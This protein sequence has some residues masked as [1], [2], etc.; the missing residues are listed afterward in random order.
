MVAPSKKFSREPTL[1]MYQPINPRPHSIGA[2]ALIRVLLLN[3]PLLATTLYP[4]WIEDGYA[5]S[6][7]PNLRINAGAYREVGVIAES[8]NQSDCR[9]TAIF[10]T[11][12]VDACALTCSK[13]VG[14]DW[15][16]ATVEFESQHINR[17]VCRPFDSKGSSTVP[18]VRF[19]NS[20]SRSKA[21]SNSVW[22]A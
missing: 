22:P 15:W 9:S 2:L 20:L 6:L 13:A 17:T 14:C 10:R 7:E 5:I 8:C 1:I 4:N 16:S 12:P 11:S 3:S 19:E 21:C 18:G